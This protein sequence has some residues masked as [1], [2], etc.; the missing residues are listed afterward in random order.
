MQIRFSSKI[1][2]PEI[3]TPV[4]GY[5]ARDVSVA[6]ADELQLSMLYLDNGI[7]QALMISYDLLGMDEKYL[8]NIRHRC[9]EILGVNDSY[10]ILSCTHTHSGP[11]TRT[12]PAYPEVLEKAYLEELIKWTADAL[13]ILLQQIPIDTDVFYYSANCTQNVNRRYIGP[14]NSCSFLPHRRDMIRIADG[15]TDREL[16]LMYFFDK[17][18][19]Q[20]VY[21]IGNFAAHPLAGHA[22]GLGSHRISADYP[23]EFRRYLQAESGAECMFVS[24]AAGDMIPIGDETGR[25]AARQVGIALARA[26]LDGMCAVQRDPQRFRVNNESLESGVVVTTFPIR[27]GRPITLPPD[28]AGKTTVDLAIQLLSIGDICFVGVPGE[29]VSELGLEIKWHSPFRKTFILYCST[30]YFGY[31][32]HGN[33]LV[34]GGYEGNSQWLTANAGLSLINAAIAEAYE[35]RYRAFP[36][37]PDYPDSIKTPLVALKNN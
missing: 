25:D 18:T 21:T 17:N 5:G 11:N 10:V 12:L 28:Y 4:A 2:S 19:K 15:V 6:K 35:L 33:A 26:A 16:G 7:Q 13:Q 36:D 32:C 27:K 30:A 14:E 37:A 3:G 1:I 31:I 23:G 20:P 34:S 9:A 24:G 22:P 29:L 8:K